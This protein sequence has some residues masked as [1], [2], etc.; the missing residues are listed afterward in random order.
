M[1]IQI[2]EDVFGK[3]FFDTVE[4]IAVDIPEIDGTTGERQNL[5]ELRESKIKLFY[6]TDITKHIMQWINSMNMMHYQFDIF[7]D[8]EPMQYTT[9]HASAG[10]HY[11]WHEDDFI[12][13]DRRFVRKL[14][15]SILLSDGSEYEGGDLQIENYDLPH[16]VT[17]SK[18]NIILFPSF[19]KHR[20]TPVTKGVR[21]S[22][23]VWVSGPSWR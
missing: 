4:Q 18:G 20:V 9:Y 12:L 8:C 7:N 21:K 16:E 10:G 13:N 15:A 23:V 5:S 17:R 3:A 11:D 22:L 1:S 14:S 6:D 19:L 2:G